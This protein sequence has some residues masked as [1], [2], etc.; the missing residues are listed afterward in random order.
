MMSPGAAPGR[1]AARPDGPSAA[2]A[3]SRRPHPGSSRRARSE[4]RCAAAASSRA[5]VDAD[6]TSDRQP[7]P[8]GQVDDRRHRVALEVERA[9]AAGHARRAASGS[10]P[11]PASA[12]SSCSRS[13]FGCSTRIRRYAA[14]HG[15]QRARRPRPPGRRAAART[16]S[17]RGSSAGRRASPWPRSP[18][19]TPDRANCG[20][21]ATAPLLSDGN[22][23]PSRMACTCG[24]DAPAADP[25]RRPGRRAHDSALSTSE[26][27]IASRR[28]ML[29]RV[30]QAN[31]DVGATD[32][33]GSASA[34]SSARRTTLSMTT[35]RI[36]LVAG[37]IG[38]AAEQVDAP[39]GVTRCAAACSS[40]ASAAS[41]IE[42]RSRKLCRGRRR[43]QVGVLEHAEHL[44][45]RSTHRHVPQPALQHVHQHGLGRQVRGDACAPG[46]SSPAEI[47]TS[48]PTVRQPPPG[49]AGR[50]R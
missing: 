10:A 36:A 38:A 43:Q 15:V 13:A 3:T 8:A 24:G 18:T 9:A 16:S 6:A 29:P 1:R 22:P 47:G 4:H 35:D 37:G 39:G 17:G 33:A 32:P 11:C 19:P 48:R 30:S 46:R 23:Q 49:S 34:S 7:T 26:D 40:S 50:G 45:A 14:G 5:G 12:S 31:P 28:A 20:L 21:D 2:A 27:G 41:P 25:S 44:A 42:R